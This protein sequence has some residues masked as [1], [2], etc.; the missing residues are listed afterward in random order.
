MYGK[1]KTLRE[2]H[3][4]YDVAVIRWITAWL[5]NRITTRVIK[6]LRVSVTSLTTSV[7]TM[8]FLIEKEISLMV[9]K[10]YLKGHM[11]NRI[12]HSWSFYMK[13]MKLA[14]GSFH[15]FHMK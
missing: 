3:L 6:L 10:A 9:I 4:S 14:K 11:I 8:C 15:K 12:L 1:V 7:S 13:F 5:K 2:L